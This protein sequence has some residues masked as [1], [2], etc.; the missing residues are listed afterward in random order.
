MYN[1]E[2]QLFKDNAKATLYSTN[3][4]IKSLAYDESTGLLHAG[5]TSGRSVFKNL[6]R[7]DNTTDPISVSLSAANGLVAEE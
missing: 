3:S 2:R 7:I 6:C 5:T 1:D 4:D